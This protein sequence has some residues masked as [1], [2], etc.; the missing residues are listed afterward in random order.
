MGTLLNSV[1]GKQKQNYGNV[2]FWHG[3]E[4]S[5]WLLKQGAFPFRVMYDIYAK[6]PL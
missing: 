6:L 1:F 3:A 4:R 2:E 5:G